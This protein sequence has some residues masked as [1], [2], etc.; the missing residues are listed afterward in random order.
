MSARSKC[1]SVAYSWWRSLASARARCNDCSRLR[2]NVGIS[3]FSSL[4]LDAS[5]QESLLFHDALQ[6][7]LMF[8]GKVHNLRHLGFGDLVGKNP[9]LPDPMLVHMHHDAMRRF[10]IFVK[11]TLEHVDHKFH[12]RVVVIE[13]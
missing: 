11:E 8:A 4:V 5:P 7:M 6:R 13:Q 2:E 3:I 12:R 9:A 10:A 1:S